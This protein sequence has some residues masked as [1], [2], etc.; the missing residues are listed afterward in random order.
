MLKSF[1]KISLQRA[2]KHPVYSVINIIGL[3]IGLA[4]FILVMLWVKNELSY[5]QFHQNSNQLYRIAFTNKTREYFGY[6]QTGTLAAYLKNEFPEITESTSF[7]TSEC[8][9]AYENLGFECKG[10]YA[11]AG[12]FNMFS[13][14]F[15]HGNKA[16]S[17]SQPNSAV[18][19][20]TLSKKLFGDEDPVGKLV[21]VNE[22]QKCTVTGVISDLPQNTSMQF[23][24]LMPFSDT[25]E[26]MR[27]W[28]SK[29]TM[30]YVM[31]QEGSEPEE[32]SRKIS[33]VMDE[34]QPSWQNTLFLVSL[35]ESHLHNLEGG[36]LIVYI[37]I[38]SLMAIVVL[39]LACINFTN[40]STSRSEL[41]IKEIFVK[42]IVGSKG[43]HIS[44]QFLFESI[45]LSL[46][47]LVVAFLLS[48]VALPFV[49][50]TLQTQLNLTFNAVNICTLI[51]VAILASLLAGSYP[52]LHLSK[53]SP[54][55]ILKNMGQNAQY[56]KWN[57]RYMLVIFQFTVSIFFISCVFMVLKQ[58]H[59]LQSKDLGIEKENIIQLS[60]RGSLSEKA[61]D[62][63][64][65]LLKYPNIESVTLSNNNMTS[66]NNSGPIEWEG[67][68]M[69]QVIEIGYNWVDFDFLETFKLKMHEGRFFSKNFTSDQ[70]NSFI[71]NQKAVSYLGLENPVGMKVKSWFGVEGTIIGIIEDFTTTSLH[72][73]L[74][75]IAL[76]ASNGNTNHMFIRTNGQE[77]PETLKYIHQ[78]V[79]EFVPDD[80]CNYQFFDEQINKLYKSEVMTGKIAIVLT[81]LAIF[82]SG[83]GL[84]G[85]ALATL[86]QRI[87]EVGIRKVNGAKVSE[88]LAML[89][90]DFLK[91]VAIAFVIA[92]PVAYFAMHKWLENFAYKT[93]LSWWIFA[94]AGVLALGI[95]LLTVS[96]QSWRAATRNPVEALRYE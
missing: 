79:R 72:N 61:T 4:C 39:A 63:K 94:L 82:I 58:V 78:K 86:N 66:W 55:K 1:L 96:W 40:L 21:K 68:D 70:S 5:D 43:L 74:G 56:K 57:F 95:A 19:T 62:L 81:L 30:T 93:T 65:E 14:P 25:Q 51:L 90:K 80:P 24:L 8:K 85:L 75:P 52:A 32:V 7:N 22:Y 76:L 44:I 88:I 10:S 31:L 67:R 34:F 11:D 50:S 49:N 89:N 2:I 17:L 64:L 87:K 37:W 38:F 3:T 18:I 33:G 60:T 36:G 15:I 45:L 23:D 35:T 54:Y 46:I 29:W 26:W 48:K 27:T 16:T 9:V 69:S 53:L 41:R 84:L 13:F 42:K 6:Y 47:S 12:F 59:Y 77:V 92:T 28:N 71:L 73:E 91:W 20:E 83:L